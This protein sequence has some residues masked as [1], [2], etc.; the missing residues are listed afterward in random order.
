MINSIGHP[1]I[2]MKQTR[3]R[4]LTNHVDAQY[5]V[6]LM[7]PKALDLGLLDL[8]ALKQR[9]D[10]PFMTLN[11][12][13]AKTLYT[14]SDFY[15]FSLPTASDNTVRLVS[16]GIEGQA[17]FGRDGEEFPLVISK[18]AFGPG[19]LITFDVISKV[20]FTVVDR[21]P[22]QMGKHVKIWVRIN[23][24]SE[25]SYVT[26]N[27]LQP[28]RQLIKL[29]DMRGLD[30]NAFHP[31]WQISGAPSVAKYKNYLSNTFIQQEYRI[32][33]GACHYLDNDSNVMD[34][35]S[36]AQY[37]DLLLEFYAVR[38]IA[39]NKFVDM[40]TPVNSTQYGADLEKAVTQGVG[41]K[42]FIS[43]L[44]AVAVEMLMKQNYNIML[45]SPG[46][47][48]LRDGY[49]T[50]RMIPGIWFQLDGAGYKTH[51]DIPTFTLSTLA[52]MIK[53][54]EAGKFTPKNR[55]ENKIYKIR[56]GMGG[57]A[58]IESAFR[59]EGF[60][61]PAQIHNTDH[62][63]IE[64]TAGN[65]VYNIPNFKMFQVEELGYITIEYDP[66]LDPIIADDVV[67]PYVTTGRRLSSYV[68]I[69]EDYNESADNIIIIRK[70][71]T[72]G[73]VIMNI[74]SGGLYTHPIMEMGYNIQGQNVTVSSKSDNLTGFKVN[75]TTM[76][77]T[78]IV[79]DPTRLLKASPKNPK[80]GKFNL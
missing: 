34:S 26:K 64:G 71:G 24:N 8:F 33:D 35:K 67:N 5:V 57:K 56:T 4:D 44:D 31:Y 19:A 25:V 55:V 13:N 37:K 75:F 21:V 72:G 46:I 53:D 78:A 20:S 18:K 39:D 1:G 6:N 45:W 70:E 29:A 7:Q 60:N 9:T 74:E 28:G 80:T 73:K 69:I 58:L 15:E 62:N 65:L 63:F 16:G 10:V 36:L 30:F 77:D 68:M 50:R 59:K 47:N 3:A 32:T 54:F 52:D 2:F 51:Y 27:D 14:Q 40:N 48:Q 76:V 42:S 11:V 22:E 49:D 43:F 41:R 12:E 79:V 38:G 23:E 17:K 61:V 66:G